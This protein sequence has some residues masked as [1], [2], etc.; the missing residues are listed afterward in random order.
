MSDSITIGD[1]TRQLIKKFRKAG[2]P[3]PELDARLLITT[4]LDMD[5]SNLILAYRHKMAA[6]QLSLLDDLVARRLSGEPVDNIL[7]WREFY[8]RIFKINGNVLSPRPDTET[9]IDYALDVLDNQTDR[10]L[11][12]GVGSGA[13]LFTLLCERP[14]LNGIGID[15]SKPALLIAEENARHL[16]I[17]DRVDLIHGS[18]YEPLKSYNN[19]QF[20]LILSNPPYIDKAYMEKLAPEVADHDPI[21]ALY[22]GEDGLDAYRIIISNAKNYLKPQG[23]LILEIGYDQAESV[24]KLLRKAGFNMI[25]LHQDLGRN[26]RV[27]IAY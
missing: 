7:G 23:K 4:V 17:K 11:D 10:I 18:W 19:Q 15:L 16:D 24:T 1:Y 21:I 12:L 27:L 13:I 26:D 20:D 5:H 25:K 22:G 14:H 8:G 3:T 2:L 9:L 6:D